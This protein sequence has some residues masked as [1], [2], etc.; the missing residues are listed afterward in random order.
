MADLSLTVREALRAVAVPEKAP[1]MQAY[2]KSEMPYLGVSSAPARAVFAE[3]FADLDLSSAELW[4]DQVLALWRGAEYRE[5]RYAA[6]ALAG[7]P[8]AEPYQVPKALGLYEEMIV[9]G[10]WWDYVD[11]LASQRVGGLL[12]RHP[13]A[14]RPKMLAWSRDRDV[15]KART[16]IICQLRFKLDT[17]LELLAACIEPSLGSKEFFLRK[18]IG[19]AL[20]QYAWVDADWVVGYVAKHEAELSPLSR[21]EALKNVSR[22]RDS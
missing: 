6:M 10:A 3:V 1:D 16:S 9:T 11:S 12:Q 14:M 17:D 7:D 4:R 8:R 21:R 19:W 22:K 15:W 2:M 18:A 13:S 20:R 5:E